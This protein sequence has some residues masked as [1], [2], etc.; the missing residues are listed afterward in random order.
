MFRRNWISIA[1]IGLTLIVGASAQEANPEIP[2][3]SEY[4][5]APEQPAELNGAEY[6]E[7]V[8][9]AALVPE[10]DPGSPVVDQET[11]ES[12]EQAGPQE[13]GFWWDTAAQWLM[14]WLALAGVGISGWAVLLLK[15]TLTATNDTL[16]AANLANEEAR[17]AADAAHEANRPWVEVTTPVGVLFN[18]GLELG[19]HVDLIAHLTNHGNSPATNVFA[20][21]ALGAVRDEA[22]PSGHDTRLAV[23]AA[24][25]RI[26]ALD[27]P[28]GMTVFP[29][30]SEGQEADA[31][32]DSS[33]MAALLEQDARGVI[34]WVVAVGATYKFGKKRCRTVRVYALDLEPGEINYTVRDGDQS[35]ALGTDRL[36]PAIGGCIT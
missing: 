7:E 14:A 13:R 23:E 26:D 15:K 31:D 36:T 20:A 11:S 17:R 25:D 5:S 1:A 2:P 12:S 3:S 16:D 30:N 29:K 27:P 6:Q 9:V 35:F 10:S 21:A 19:G 34:H 33:L 4:E 18:V 8:W 32:F 24:L 28:F 22:Q